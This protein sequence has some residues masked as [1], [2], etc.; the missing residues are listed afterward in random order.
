M[1]KDIIDKQL[2]KKLVDEGNSYKDISKIMGYRESSLCRCYT[3]NFG[4]KP[5]R[6]ISYRQKIEIS[7]EQKEI[8]FGSLMG[9]MFIG[10]HT[11]TYRGTETHSIKQES[12]IKYKHSLLSP[13]CGKLR[14]EKT[15]LK[16]KI[17]YKMSF[18]LRP[19]LNLKPFYDM[20]Y[21][22]E[23]NKKDVPYNLSLLTPRAIAFWFMD[24][25]FKITNK[26]N[27]LGFSTC[28]FSMDGLLRLQKYLFET[29]NIDTI[30]R[31]NFYLIVRACSYNT[32]C[33][34][35]KPY[36]IPSMLYKLGLS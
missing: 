33:T 28:S 14:D 20:F 10:K 15:V 19:N 1:R 22:G 3:K 32:F 12:Y 27:L 17:Y 9:D 6:A 26:N 25:G 4:I 21:I 29:F 5:D 16:N 2:L 23:N 35:I 11:K 7:E 13:L 30:I 18:T 8:L 31:K 24:D 36:I 34:L